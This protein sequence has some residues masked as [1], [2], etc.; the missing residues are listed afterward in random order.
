MRLTIIPRLALVAIMIFA[1]TS[2]RAELKSGEAKKLI[3]RIAGSQ[4][5]G[6][7][8]R[9]KRI[10]S[11]DSNS[12]AATAEIEA[13]FK[14]EEA[15]NG[16]WVVSEVRV[17]PDRWED[18]GRISRAVEIKPDSS[19]THCANPNLGM[20]KRA[21]SEPSVRRARCLIAHLLGVELPSDAIRI[22]E[23]SPLGL[24]AASSISATVVAKVQLDFRFANAGK[25]GWQLTAVRA[26]NRDWVGVGN[27]VAGLDAAKRETA[28]RDMQTVAIALEKF[29]R[30]RGFYVASDQERVLIDHLSPKYL[31]RVVR[32]DPWQKPYEYL[33]DRDH[34]TLRSS[35]PDGKPNTADDV[36]LSSR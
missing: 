13:V 24:P 30:D 32:V 26:G 36:V 35:G 10:S 4:L 12:A 22:K 25:G 34:F 23:V 2:A 27:L 33:G 11:V 21:V 29:R 14:L 17:A 5:P 6:S 1:A 28:L 16:E 7:S 15:S 18:I 9:I 3:S 20:A 19:E 31:S 8:V